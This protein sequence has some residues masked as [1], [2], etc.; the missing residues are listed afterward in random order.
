MAYAKVRIHSAGEVWEF[1]SEVVTAF[2]LLEL[3]TNRMDHIGTLTVVGG[4]I[5]EDGPYEH[6]H[7]NIASPE[8]IAIVTS[9]HASSSG[10]AHEIEDRTDEM[11]DKAAS[12]NPVSIYPGS[13]NTTT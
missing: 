8:Q 1:D 11:S 10:R 13:W 9:E 2:A 6:V 7:L 3:V 4:R 12:R 5:R